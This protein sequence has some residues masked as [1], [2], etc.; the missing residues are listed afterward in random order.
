MP[1][2]TTHST[3]PASFYG[4]A[5]VLVVGALVFYLAALRSGRDLSWAVVIKTPHWLQ[6]LA[7]GS[8]CLLYTSDAADE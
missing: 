6:M 3:I 5:G 2:V 1:Q 7:Q 4:A 8:L